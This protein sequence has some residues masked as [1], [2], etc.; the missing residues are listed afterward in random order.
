MKRCF[1]FLALFVSAGC[2][3]FTPKPSLLDD[4]AC[5][6]PCWQN[7]VPGIS[8]KQDALSTLAQLAFIDQKSIYAYDPKLVPPKG[9]PIQVYDEII[10]SEIAFE[11]Q[12]YSLLNI[13]MLKDKVSVISFQ[14]RND[15]IT[16]SEAINKLGEPEYIVISPYR[17]QLVFGF[18]SPSVGVAFVYSTLGLSKKALFEVYPDARLESIYF[19]D[20]KTY[21]QFLE[22]RFLT[23]NQRNSDETRANLVPWKGYGEIKELY[24]LK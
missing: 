18:V 13:Y 1:I 10:D 5:P 2:Q 9:T 16:L 15:D 12:F 8:T 11:D 3:L 22:S 23:F 20:P 7:I 4:L 21:E 6:P 14:L 17:D 19:F 24:P